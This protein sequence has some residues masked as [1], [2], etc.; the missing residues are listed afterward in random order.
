MNDTKSWLASRTIWGGLIAVAA[1]VAGWAG[2]NIDPETQ[3]VLTDRILE[4]VTVAG[5]ILAIVGRVL[6]MKE[7]R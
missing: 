1:V 6:A 4:I 7:V 3:G 2:F 5:S